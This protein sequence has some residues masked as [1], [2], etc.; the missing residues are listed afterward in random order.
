MFNKLTGLKSEISFLSGFPL[1]NGT[2]VEVFALFGNTLFSILEFMA[3]V[4]IGGKKLDAILMS[5]GKIVSITTTF[6]VSIS[7]RSFFTLSTVVGLKEKNYLFLITIRYY[8]IS[9]LFDAGMIWYRFTMCWVSSV[10]FILHVEEMVSSIIQLLISTMFIQWLLNKSASFF[11]SV[12]IS[13]SFLRVM[14]LF[15][16]NTLFVR[17]GLKKFQKILCLSLYLFS[18]IL[19]R[20]CF[21]H[22]LRKLTYLLF[23]FCKPLCFQK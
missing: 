22:R 14:S 4:S 2:T 3:V 8:I 20:C 10:P 19:A 13:F 1:S 9:D 18:V 6:S 16:E 11:S 17:K 15:F 23:C 5:L 7:F 21:I 12:M